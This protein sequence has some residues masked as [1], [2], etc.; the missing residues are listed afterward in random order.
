MLPSN[1]RSRF[2][3]IARV[4]LRLD[5]MPKLHRKRGSLFRVGLRR[6]LARRRVLFSDIARAL[7]IRQRAAESILIG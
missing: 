2:L 4:L 5:H 1:G 7:P 3:E 6:A